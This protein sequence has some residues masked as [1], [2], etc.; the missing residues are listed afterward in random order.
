MARMNRHHPGMLLVYV[1][2][3]LAVLA[4]AGLVLEVLI[5]QSAR[6]PIPHPLF[7]AVSTT[8][9][10]YWH[11]GVLLVPLTALLAGTL[12]ARRQPDVAR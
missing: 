11:S 6:V 12:A 9:P 7:Y 2:S 4:V 8:L 5:R 1:V 10:F 3:I